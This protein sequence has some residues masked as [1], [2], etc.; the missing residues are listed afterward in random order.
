M[1]S[2]PAKRAAKWQIIERRPLIDTD[3][4]GLVLKPENTKDWSK[5]QKN[6]KPEKIEGCFPVFILL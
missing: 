1:R 4:I 2:A 5:K 3:A 6:P